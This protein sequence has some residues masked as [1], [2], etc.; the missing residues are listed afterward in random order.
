MI[1]EN[2]MSDRAR[3]AF[4]EALSEDK[5]VSFQELVFTMSSQALIHLGCVPNPVTGKAEA[6]LSVAQRTID[7]LGVL[8]QKTRGNLDPQEQ[9]VLANA[10][11]NLRLRFVEAVRKLKERK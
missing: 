8:E 10:L 3:T 6:N 7:M 9:E 1:S 2:E 5:K 11:Y 4:T